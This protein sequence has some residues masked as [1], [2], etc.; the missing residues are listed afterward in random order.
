MS[1]NSIEAEICAICM[2]KIGDKNYS[3]LACQHYFCL[4]CIFSQY[5]YKNECP[6]CRAIILKDKIKLNKNHFENNQLPPPV[7]SAPPPPPNYQN[8]RTLS[9][10]TESLVNTLIEQVNILTDRIKAQELQNN[11]NNAI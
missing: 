9:T 11:Y 5:T 2:C 1:S 3:K 10:T 7:P 6:T 8:T 4:P